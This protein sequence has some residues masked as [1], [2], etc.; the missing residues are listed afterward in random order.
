MAQDY[1]FGHPVN[2]GQ[3][4]ISRSPGEGP[5]SANRYASMDRLDALLRLTALDRLPR[6]GWVQAG[7]PR[8]ETIAG[9]VVGTAYLVLALGPEVRPELDLDRAVAL[10]VVHD[11]GE[12]VLTDLPRTASRLFPP[13]AKAGAE[14][15]AAEELLGA[16][17][18]TAAERVAEALGDGTREARFVRLCDRLQMGVQLLAYHRIGL[19]GLDE[20]RV[21]I[22]G[23][24]CS[25]FEACARLREALLERLSR[26]A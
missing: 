8:P 9:H 6:S 26:P 16:L 12:A 24:D 15:Q 3:R 14:A 20:F 23:M 22:E 11:A 19:R 7:V 13:G 5:P 4:P 10:A 21:S 25:E 17:S 18:P 2:R 1:R